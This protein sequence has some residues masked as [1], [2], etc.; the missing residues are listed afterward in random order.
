MK[1]KQEPPVSLR[2]RLREDLICFRNLYRSALQSVTFPIDSPAVKNHILGEQGGRRRHKE[3]GDPS[4]ADRTPCQRPGAHGRMVT[5]IYC[6]CYCL[7]T[8]LTVV[9][10][11]R[12]HVPVGS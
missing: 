7:P 11:A 1:H 12:W 9:G 10:L 2:A 3:K 6:S 5:R 8:L 4:H